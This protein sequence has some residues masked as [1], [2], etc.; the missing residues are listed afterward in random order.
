MSGAFC[1]FCVWLTK[2]AA[3]ATMPRPGNSFSANFA[4]LS[5]L[6]PAVPYCASPHPQQAFCSPYAITAG[7]SNCM[8]NAS[9]TRQLKLRWSF[10]AIS[11]DAEGPSPEE[12]GPSA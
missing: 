11:E 2:A 1:S 12:D 6:A 4:K 10:L 5:A 7:R 3:P 8:C 9:R